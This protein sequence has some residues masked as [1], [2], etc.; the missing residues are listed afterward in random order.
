M[1]SNTKYRDKYNHM[2]IQG[3]VQEDKYRNLNCIQMSGV[4]VIKYQ[5]L[6]VSTTFTRRQIMFQVLSCPITWSTDYCRALGTSG[7][8]GIEQDLGI[9]TAPQSNIGARIHLHRV[10]LSISFGKFVY[11]QHIAMHCKWLKKFFS[12][13]REKKN[14][15]VNCEQDPSWVVF[16]LIIA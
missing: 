10:F 13:I 14:Q 2:Q 12:Y 5:A 1:E 7:V 3:Q 4:S 9:P 11:L 15:I 16:V 6:I 8:G